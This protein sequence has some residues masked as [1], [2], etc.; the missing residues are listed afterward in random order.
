MQLHY[1]IVLYI[2]LSFSFPPFIHNRLFQ[3]Q[4]LEEVLTRD[5]IK[6]Y[7][8]MRCLFSFSVYLCQDKEGQIKM[9]SL[10]P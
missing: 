4:Q 2:Y 10:R 7:P 1:N 6:Y 3:K 9:L 5:E 8:K